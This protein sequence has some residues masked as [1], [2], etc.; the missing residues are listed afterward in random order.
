MNKD[1][2]ILMCDDENIPVKPLNYNPKALPKLDVITWGFATDENEN[3]PTGRSIEDLK[4]ASYYNL[5]K[6]PAEEPRDN[7]KWNNKPEVNLNVYQIHGKFEKGFSGSP[8]CYTWDNNV[9]GIFTAITDNNGYV[10]PIQTLLKKFNK[11][12]KILTAQSTIDTKKY[13]EE[14]NLSYKKRHLNNAIDQYNKIISDVD[15]LSALNN[16]GASLMKLGKY[17]ES[18][19]WYDKALKIN[20]N[21][22]SA[23]DA[24]KLAL[25]YLS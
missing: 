2:A 16:K 10:I 23:Q 13:L 3:I 18:I 6:W 7:N 25:G 4:L 8:V 21:H 14:G 11:D 19:E 24:K 17:E 22:T 12:N 1:L 20:P 9:I 15:Y 5:F